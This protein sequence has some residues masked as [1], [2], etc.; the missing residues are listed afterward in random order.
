MGRDRNSYEIFGGKVRKKER[1]HC[2]GGP[3][4]KI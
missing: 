3:N 4:S 2:K 1:N